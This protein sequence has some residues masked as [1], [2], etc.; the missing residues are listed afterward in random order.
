MTP[1]HLT[2]RPR[3]AAHAIL[4]DTSLRGTLGRHLTDDGRLLTIDI[5]ID[6]H[7]RMSSGERVLYG[8]IESLADRRSTTTW[9]EIAARLD[10]PSQLAVIDALRTLCGID[11]E[12]A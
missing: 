3:A 6:V 9:H 12:A 11:V 2:G 10:H 5:N 1:L 8:V 4:Q 7:E